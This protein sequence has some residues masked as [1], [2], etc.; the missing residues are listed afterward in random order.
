M[1]LFQKGYVEEK[2]EHL[3]LLFDND[4]SITLCYLYVMLWIVNQ[5]LIDIVN[6]AIK[7][8]LYLLNYWLNQ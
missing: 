4:Q 2:I 1:L 6:K 3:L 5:Q 7:K 8:L